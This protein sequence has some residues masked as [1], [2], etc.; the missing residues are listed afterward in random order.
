MHNCNQLCY[1]TKNDFFYN[2]KRREEK[3]LRVI[4]VFFSFFALSQKINKNH[5]SFMSL[6]KTHSTFVCVLIIQIIY[7]KTS[8]ASYYKF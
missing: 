7:M 3:K 2:T 6:Y 1:Y 4:S 8:S 5:E